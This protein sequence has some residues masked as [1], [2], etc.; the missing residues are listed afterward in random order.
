MSGF[1]PYARY[2]P[3]ADAIY[4]YL[5][6]KPIAF[7]HRL[8]DYRL[9]DYSADGAVVGVEFLG[10]SG[11]IDRNDLPLSPSDRAAI[12]TLLHAALRGPS[13]PPPAS[14]SGP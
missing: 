1:R 3:T 4:V 12:L 11:G 6:N 8:D 13:T 9:I 2:S 10:I 14:A 5:S 7:S